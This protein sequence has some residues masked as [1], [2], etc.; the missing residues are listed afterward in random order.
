MMR[1]QEAYMMRRQEAYMMRRQEAEDTKPAALNQAPRVCFLLG[2][3]QTC[4]AH[5]ASPA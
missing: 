2:G 4:V 1:R 5:L 3:R